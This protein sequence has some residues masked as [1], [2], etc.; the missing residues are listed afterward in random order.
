[1]A[2][3]KW[4][5]N[6]RIP[7]LFLAAP[8][9]PDEGHVHISSYQDNVVWLTKIGKLFRIGYGTGRCLQYGWDKYILSCPT[10]QDI[11][12]RKSKVCGCKIQKNHLIVNMTSTNKLKPVI[13]YKSLCPRCF[14]RWL[15]TNYVSW[16][17]NQM[18]WMP[19]YVFK[20]W[21]MSLNAHFKSQKWKVLLIIN[22]YATNSLKHFGRVKQLIFSTLHLSNIIFGCL[23]PNATSVVQLLD[24][25]LFA[26]F[27]SI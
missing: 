12:A 3:P 4:L 10:K 22:N 11:S 23:P 19:S 20:C 21:M 16:F 13:S 1:M 7:N 14:G 27:S 17:V 6:K 26:S 8:P 18:A 15:P 2:W 25:G 24:Q 9:P 5:W